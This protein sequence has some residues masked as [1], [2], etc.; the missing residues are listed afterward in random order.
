M[1]V[2][3]TFEGEAEVEEGSAFAALQGLL[4]SGQRVLRGLDERFKEE[5][6]FYD[7]KE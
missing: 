4:R 1:I 6:G 2:E 3:G 7:G 5:R